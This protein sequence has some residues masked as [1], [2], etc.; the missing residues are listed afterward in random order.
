MRPLSELLEDAIWPIA[1]TLMFWLSF[2]LNYA[3]AL[4][5]NEWGIQPHTLKGTAGILLSPLLHG[6][7]D[8]LFSNTT[9]FFVAA[10]LLFHYYPLQRWRIFGLIWFFSGFSVWLYARPMSN[11]IGAS[12]LV[13]GLVA[14]L[15][16]SAVIKR[17]TKLLAGSLI[18]VLLYGNMIWG[19]FPHQHVDPNVRISWEGHLSGALTGIILAWIFRFDGPVNPVY[20]AVEE[21]NDDEDNDQ[22]YWKIPENEEQISEDTASEKPVT[23]PLNPPQIRYH[24]RKN[25]ED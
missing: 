10:F 19:V 7:P 18:L 9:P 3:Y 8:H 11:H 14:F 12:G 23:D 17:N 4:D 20:F 16:A 21:E 22:A 13:Y 25:H 15:L 6:N 24:F 1:M 5:W 2:L